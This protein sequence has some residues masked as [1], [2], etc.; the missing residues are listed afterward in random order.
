MR[1]I[2]ISLSIKCFHSEICKLL[3]YSCSS[4][5]CKFES[6]TFYLIE[7][8]QINFKPAWTLLNILMQTVKWRKI[9]GLW[10]VSN[11]FLVSKRERWT[12]AWKWS[13]ITIKRLSTSK[14]S[15]ITSVRYFRIPPVIFAAFQNEQSISRKIIAK[16]RILIKA[17]QD[18]SKWP[19][20]NTD[21]PNVPFVF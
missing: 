7:A 3:C 2:S 13:N 20:R 21:R 18:W 1:N 11:V 8:F 10:I 9:S 4:Y 6:N 5:L 15:F 19:I 16:T 12:L 14:T 17:T